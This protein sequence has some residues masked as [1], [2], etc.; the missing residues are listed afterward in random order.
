MRRWAATHRE[1]LAA[2]GRRHS[3]KKKYQI[4][5]EQYET[6]LQQQGGVCAI[7]SA[8]PGKRRLHVDHDHATRKIR[9]LLCLRCNVTVGV[10]EKR[11]ELLQLAAA[12]VARHK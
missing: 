12:Y 9:G 5:V 7:C 2:R 4:T 3:L 11:A 1:E 6:M 8:A 10:V